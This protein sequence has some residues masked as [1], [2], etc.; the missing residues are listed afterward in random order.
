MK[1]DFIIFKEQLKAGGDFTQPPYRIRAA[2]LDTNF[3]RCRPKAQDGEAANG[4][5]VDDSADGWELLPQTVF[6]VC[7]NGKPVKYQFIAKRL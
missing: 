5:K 1:S 4:Y 3:A 2:D 7:E 6:D